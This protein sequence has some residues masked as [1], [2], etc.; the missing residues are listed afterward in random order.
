MHET[1][2]HTYSEITKMPH[3]GL[4][5]VIDLTW[6]RRDRGGKWLVVERGH[7]FDPARSGDLYSST[8]KLVAT[9]VS[10][11]GAQIRAGKARAHHRRHGTSARIDVVPREAVTIRHSGAMYG[12]MSGEVSA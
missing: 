12:C 6:N 9:S 2:F 5:E 4:V 3:A 7:T 1:I 11:R 10:Y 8:G